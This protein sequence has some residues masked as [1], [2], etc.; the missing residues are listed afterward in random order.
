M[1]LQTAEGA[2]LRLGAEDNSN[3][4]SHSLMCVHPRNLKEGEQPLNQTTRDR[5]DLSCSLSIQVLKPELIFVPLSSP[6]S[7]FVV[8]PV[9]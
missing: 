9:L 7:Q 6:Q 3:L 4:S 8:D 2:L 5:L 1:S